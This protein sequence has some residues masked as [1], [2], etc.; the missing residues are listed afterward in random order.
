MGII[1]GSNVPIVIEFDEN[2]ENLP[3]IIITLWCDEMI[4]RGDPLKMWNK[5]DIT[6]SNN[7]AVCPITEDETAK[8]PAA[9]LVMEVK[10]LDENGKTV[11]WKE[12][13]V[14]VVARRDRNIKLTRQG[15]G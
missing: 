11:F 14:D 1:Q 8:L 10:G 12:Y 4:Y 7:M 5:E 9:P 13:E 6:V 3:V 15:S 2:I